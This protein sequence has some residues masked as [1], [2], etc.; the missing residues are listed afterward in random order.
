MKRENS[1]LGTSP[2]HWV[3][4]KRRGECKVTAKG[5]AMMRTKVKIQ[6][7]GGG[8]T[9]DFPENEYRGMGRGSVEQQRP[10]END[11][12]KEEGDMLSKKSSQ[13]GGKDLRFQRAVKVGKEK[14]DNVGRNGQP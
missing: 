11:R 12:G 4:A 3:D 13:C 14:M 2:M 10:S 8:G 5:P 9:S 7:L 1:A 6:I